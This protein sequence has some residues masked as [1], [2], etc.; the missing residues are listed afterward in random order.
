MTRVT[1]SAVTVLALISSLRA[2]S[3]YARALLR[4]LTRAACQTRQSMPAGAGRV[5]NASISS[6]IESGK[7]GAP[8]SCRH[9]CR[10]RGLSSMRSPYPGDT[11][12]RRGRCRTRKLRRSD[13]NE[14]WFLERPIDMA[15]F[16]YLYRGAATPMSTPELGAERTAAFGVWMQTVGAALV[17]GGRPFGSSA[18]VRD[19]GTEAT[20]GDLIGYT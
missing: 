11:V 15:K 12:A 1:D 8:S 4:P 20:P 3:R 7:G 9:A 17:E 13:S 14:S 16:M 2:P 5:M 18:S 19:D 6:S 10:A